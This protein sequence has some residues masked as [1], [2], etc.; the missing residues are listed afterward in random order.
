MRPWAVCRRVLV[1]WPAAFV[2]HSA[3]SLAPINGGRTSP[4]INSN[5]ASKTR[6]SSKQTKATRA[7]PIP[8]LT[9]AKIG[10]VSRDYNDDYKNGKRDFSA[11]FPDVLKLLDNEGCDTVVFSLYSIVPRESFRPLR[12]VSRL[13]L[14][15][16]S[17]VLYEEFI[18][19]KKRQIVRNVVLYR[20]RVRWLEYELPKGGIPSLK[21]LTTKRKREKVGKYRQELPHLGNCCAILCGEIN[22]VPYHKDAKRVQD[23]FGL[24]KSLPKNVKVVLNSG[25]DRMTRF[26]MPLKRRFLSENGRWV[27]SV[28]N[29]GRPRD[30]AKRPWSVWH[31]GEEETKEVVEP[32]HEIE[33]IEIGVVKV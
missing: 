18:D 15:H 23:D 33:K 17:A 13:R 26:E 30:G 14:R 3:R 4:M 22:C 9:V 24:R 6:S 20:R 11:A 10:I 31:D 27:I 2:L 8:K 7:K 25:H 16:V 29:R 28:W 19:G 5:S 1:F 21:G 32:Q 12:V